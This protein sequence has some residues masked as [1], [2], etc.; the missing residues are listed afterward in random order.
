MRLHGLK[1]RGTGDFEP[2]TFVRPPLQELPGYLL[3]A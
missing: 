2:Y 3:A 1:V